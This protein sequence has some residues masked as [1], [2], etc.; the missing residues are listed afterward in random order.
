MSADL[1]AGAEVQ[2]ATVASYL[3]ERGDVELIAV[4]LN[5]GPLACELRRLGVAVTV[6][7]ESL[8][9]AAA[10]FVALLRVLRDHPVD[11]VHTHR[12]KDT[13]LGVIAAKLAGVRGVVRTFHGESE[14]FHGWARARY[15][16]YEAFDRVTLRCLA[17]RIV[18]VSGKMAERLDRSGYGADR[19]AC[20][21]NGVDLKR[22]RSERVREQVRRELGIAPAAPLIGTVGRLSPV[23]GHVHFLR[24]ARLILQG[25]RAA[26]F[27]VV[28]DG[29]LR[30]DLERSAKEFG[31]QDA[32]VF[33][34]ARGDVFDLVSALDVFVLPS[35]HEG[36]P[37]ALLEAM[38]LGTPVVATAVG[39]VPEVVADGVN[40]LLVASGDAPGLAEAC[41]GLVRDAMKARKLALS[42]RRTVEERFLREQNGQ[43]LVDLYRAVTRGPGTAG[44]RFL[45]HVA[46]LARPARTLAAAVSSSGG[47]TRMERVRREPDTLIARLRSARRILFVCHGNIIRSVFAARL[48]TQALGDHGQ[49]VIS[50]G[51]LAAISG[52]PSPSAATLVAARHDVDLSDHAALPITSESVATSDVILVMDVAQVRTME[53]R[54]P[55]ARGKTFLLT[56]LAPAWPPE[57]SDP[58]GRDEEAFEACFEHISAAVHPIV[59]LLGGIAAR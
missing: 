24:A 32:C 42:A 46:R 50:S 8:H 15:R 22:V 57:V 26:R 51:G 9:S 35:L 59:R 17:D 5:E 56:S 20:I 3:V 16:L 31:L 30:G 2:V 25:E 36:I 21:H 41:L 10:I 29:P 40:G 18:A 58:Y 13:V 27:L 49:A 33:A 6:I 7:D 52:K 34:G 38:A 39:G 11:V 37:M 19:V 48:A 47:K 1:W 45:E 12:N 43:A 28:G 4:L 55:G 44:Q 54:F 23:K 53:K 14:P